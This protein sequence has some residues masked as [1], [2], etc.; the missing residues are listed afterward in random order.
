MGIFK[1]N[2]SKGTLIAVIGVTLLFVGIFIGNYFQVK[3]VGKESRIPPK[4]EATNLPMKKNVSTEMIVRNTNDLKLEKEM[5]RKKQEEAVIWRNNQER[6]SSKVPNPTTT[7]IAAA[8]STT[9]DNTTSQ[10]PTKES[11]AT[12]SKQ[13]NT[14]PSKSGKKIVYLTFD[15]GPAAFSDQIIE[16]LEKYQFK[17]TFFMIDGNIRRYPEAVK[18]M[19][20]SGETVGLHSV[21]HSQKKFYKSKKTVLSELTQNRNTLEEVAGVNS[22]I[23][24]TPYGS[25]PNMTPEYKK[26]VKENGYVM[27]DWNIDSK[28][29]YYK[30]KRYVD[31][32]IA[33]IKQKKDQNGPLVILL[34][35]RKETLAHLP[36][37]LDY[38][39]KQGYEGKP[40]E[41]TTPPVQF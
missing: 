34:H 3:A 40:I 31:S 38:L 17:A 36:M 21:S 13:Q 16:L 28:D 2:W 7:D 20:E 5:M 27:W 26:A 10:P 33:Q 15:D 12:P 23:M 19:T 35:E 37:L 1:S 11:N 18:L 24:R 22:F 41:K 14:Q 32:V 39:K 9:K 29:W 8:H 30:D 25:A 4:N 6:E